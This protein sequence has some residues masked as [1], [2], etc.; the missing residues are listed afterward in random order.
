MSNITMQLKVLT[1]AVLIIGIQLNFGSSIAQNTTI[2]V[3][4]GDMSTRKNKTIKVI[5][6]EL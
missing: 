3:T 5:L 6:I 2:L 4:K 1:V